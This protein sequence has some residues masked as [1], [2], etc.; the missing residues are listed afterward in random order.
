VGS[1]FI[2]PLYSR[3]EV[4][5][6]GRTFVD[7]RASEEDRALSLAVINNWRSAHSYPLNTHQMR[8]RRIAPQFDSDPL[9]AQRLKRL[10]SIRHKLE[11]FPGFNVAQMQDL[12]GCRAVVSNVKSVNNLVR[13]YLE[14]SRQKHPLVR[15]DPYIDHPKSS[16]YRGVHL[17]YAY[18]SDK[19]HTWN[20]LR[21]E[22]QIRTRL[23]HAWATAVETVGTFTKQALKSSQGEDAWLRFF[24]LMGSAHA[25][26]EKRPLVPDT[27]SDPK[28]LRR[29]I[30]TIAAQLDV[31]NRLTTYGKTL[32]ILGDYQTRSKV[33]VLELKAA[34]GQLVLRDFHSTDQASAAYE[35][36]EKATEADPNTDVVLVTVESVNALQRAY[37]N[38]FL[39]TSVFVQSVRA[40]LS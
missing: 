9:V 8:L 10:A 18:Q 38:Y 6:A 39:D 30:R 28:E 21:T 26:S 24:A 27:P 31:V 15:H 19:V 11:R 14:E 16:G 20:G 22:L 2:E 4:K 37:P 40:A 23:Q 25:M 34:E 29:E 17:V 5:R 33:F 36:L 12:G 13:F 1:H 35:A 32:Q 7:P 3:T